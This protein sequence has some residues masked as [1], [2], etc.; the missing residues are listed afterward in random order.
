MSCCSEFPSSSGRLG[1][2]ALAVL[3]IGAAPLAGCQGLSDMTGSIA[4]TH[5]PLPTD[6]A[7]LRAYADDWGR[8]YDGK[9]GEKAA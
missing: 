4:S 5:Q 9:P 7:A 3:L 2:L 8:R 1:A 6:E